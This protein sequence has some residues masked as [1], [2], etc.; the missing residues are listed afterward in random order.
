MLEKG[1]NASEGNCI[2]VSEQNSEAIRIAV[3]N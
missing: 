3:D 2:Q 1:Q